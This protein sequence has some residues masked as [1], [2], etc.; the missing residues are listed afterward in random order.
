MK[1]FKLEAPWCTYPKKVQALFSG[2]KDIVVRPLEPD[3]EGENECDYCLVIEVK[4]HKKAV[5]LERVMSDTVSFGNVIV[6]N[7]IFD[8]E[9]SCASPTELFETLFEGNPILKDCKNIT[10]QAGV[11]H[12]YVRFQPEVIQ[13]YDDDLTDY[14]GNWSGLAASIAKEVFKTTTGIN[15]CTAAK[16]EN[17]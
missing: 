16:E 9:N 2:D 13:F 3:Y 14:N 11:I 10:D 8:E 4:N 15:F 6:R 1:S 7:M 5:A 17:E 12:S